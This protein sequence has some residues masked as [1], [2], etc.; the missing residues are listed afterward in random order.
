M[1]T[2]KHLKDK[3]VNTLKKL[4]GKSTGNKPHKATISGPRNPGC[5]QNSE[6]PM[7]AIIRKNR[8]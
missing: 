8:K 3:I 5:S 7:C 2:L 4:K 6:C 1:F